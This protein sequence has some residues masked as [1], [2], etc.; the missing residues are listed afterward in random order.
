[1]KKVIIL[2]LLVMLLL[3]PYLTSAEE[4]EEVVQEKVA[5]AP[6]MAKEVVKETVTPISQHIETAV[7]SKKKQQKNK[8][9]SYKEEQSE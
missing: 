6:M 1:M 2:S 4:T 8:F 5:V 7:V 3:I 9:K